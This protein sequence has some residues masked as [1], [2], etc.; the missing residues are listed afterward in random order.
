MIEYILITS[1]IAQKLVVNVNTHTKE[2]W[3][4][5]GGVSARTLNRYECELIQ[6][7]TR[8]NGNEEI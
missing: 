1:T 7:M 5:K 2:G 6:A 4:P 3:K 8:E